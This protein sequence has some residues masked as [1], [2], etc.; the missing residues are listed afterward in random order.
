MGTGQD[1]VGLHGL[2]S[3]EAEWLVLMSEGR[4]RKSVAEIGMPPEIRDALIVRD[5]LLGHPDGSIEITVNGTAEVIRLS[6]PVLQMQPELQPDS[7]AATGE[8]GMY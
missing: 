5:L 1:M 7:A 2:T 6:E 3:I 4:I 8:P